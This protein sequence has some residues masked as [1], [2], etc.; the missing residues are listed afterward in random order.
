MIVLKG[1]WV[2]TW[3]GGLKP[4]LQVREDVGR[5]LSSGRH[6]AGGGGN[7]GEIDDLGDLAAG[8]RVELAEVGALGGVAGLAGAAATVAADDTV[9]GGSF[10][11]GVEGTARR[12]VGE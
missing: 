5:R 10:H 11:E 7:D 12:H 6:A 8:G 9:G 1:G 3:Q 4:A 2:G